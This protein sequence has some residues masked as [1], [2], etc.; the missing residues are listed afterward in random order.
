VSEECYLND[1]AYEMSLFSSPILAQFSFTPPMLL[2]NRI[3][4][5]ILE[6]S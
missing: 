4:H 5:E 2:D 3:A 6:Q 1:A